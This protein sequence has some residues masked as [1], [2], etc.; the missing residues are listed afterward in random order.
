MPQ[1]TVD[2]DLAELIWQLAK[3]KPFENLTF[4]AALKRIHMD[5]NASI[6]GVFAA[7][8]EVNVRGATSQP[9]ERACQ[10]KA[11]SPNPAEWA[12]S[13]PELR[14]L[15][16]LSTWKAICDALRIEVAGDSARRKLKNWV[17][18]HHPKWPAVPGTES[19]V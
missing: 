18:I 9:N 11:P 14:G 17:K 4:N 3:P 12:E 10:K 16:N 19:D 6:G 5:S 2:D 13:V 7:P 15:G 1:F 8:T